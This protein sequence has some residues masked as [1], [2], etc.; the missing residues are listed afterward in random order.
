MNCATS[1]ELRRGELWR[2][3]SRTEGNEHRLI[4]GDCTDAAVVERVMGGEMAEIGFTSPPYLDMRDYGGND[5]SLETLIRF[6]PIMVRHCGYSVVNLGLKFK[7]GEVVPYW[8][9]YLSA[10]DAA[11]VK[12]LA[13]NVWDKTQGGGIAS[14]TNMFLLTHEWLFVFGGK[15]KKL[16][17]TIPNNLDAY[18]RRHGDNF[19]KDGSRKRVRKADASWIPTTSKAYTHHQL[20]SVIQQMPELGPI[21]ENHPAI[22]PIGLPQSYIKAMTSSD[23]LVYD[24][25]GGSGTTMIASEN[26]GRQCRMIEIYPSYCAVIL[27]RYFDSFSIR[28]E[29]C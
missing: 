23:D 24:P 2:L 25:F 5:L 4:C 15:R 11:G 7:D 16:N 22:M 29:I 9:D 3:P 21:R 13:W 20:H 18:A 8:N 19:L 27:Q 17:R 14:S 1:G 6:V 28:P 10:F 26:L 12:L